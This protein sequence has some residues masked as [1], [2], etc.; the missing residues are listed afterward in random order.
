M[1]KTPKGETQMAQERTADS[2]PFTPAVFRWARGRA[3]YTID[4]AAEKLGIPKDNLADWENDDGILAPT[5]KQARDLA[6]LYGRSFLE[7]FLPFPPDL[8]EPTRIPDFRLYRDVGTP[9]ED[10]DLLDA[11]IWAETQREKRVRSL[12]RNRRGHPPI[13]RKYLYDNRK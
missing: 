12:F 6:A 1:L 4:A 13:T 11:Q 5:V 2:I 8:P 10:R 7:W 9:S 3:G